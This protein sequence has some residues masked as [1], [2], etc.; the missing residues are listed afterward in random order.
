MTLFLSFESQ[1]ERTVPRV[2][3]TDAF[4]ASRHRASV[5]EP[6]EYGHKRCTIDSSGGADS[7]FF[8]KIFTELANKTSFDGSL[9][10]DSTHL[11]AH[12]TAASL[13]K[14]GFFASEQRWPNSKL[15]AV[16]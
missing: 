10:I 8:N 9:M 13:L 4:S 3:M 14:R 16:L 12:R 15:H 7:V 11:K 2:S 5:E 6:D 1:L